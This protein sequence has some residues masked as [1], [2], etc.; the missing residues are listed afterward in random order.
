M[1]SGTAS[2]PG[3]VGTTPDDFYDLGLPGSARVGSYSATI[4]LTVS[5]GP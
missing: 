1:A 2:A 5:S 4:V 3:C